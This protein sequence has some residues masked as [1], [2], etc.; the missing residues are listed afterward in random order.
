MK[1]SL[2]NNYMALM[3]L[4][5]FFLCSIYI[6]D[7]LKVDHDVARRGANMNYTFNLKYDAEIEYLAQEARKYGT[8]LTITDDSG[9]PTPR[10]MGAIEVGY[11]VLIQSLA[12]AGVKSVNNVTLAQ[13]HVFSFLFFSLIFCA[14]LGIVTRKIFPVSFVVLALLLLF[15]YHN[16]PLIYHIVGIWTLCTSFPFITFCAVLIMLKYWK[17]DFSM[18]TVLLLTAL[19]LTGGV[20]RFF[21]ES[22]SYAYFFTIVSFLAIL[23]S[24]YNRRNP[25]R[26]VINYVGSLVLVILSF[27]AVLPLIN[28]SLLYH[29]SSKTGLEARPYASFSH[30]AGHVLVVSLGR[31]ENPFGYYYSDYFA[32]ETGNKL[33]LRKGYG[34]GNEWSSEYHKVLLDYYVSQIMRHPFHYLKFLMKSFY[35]YLKFIPYSL[36]LDTPTRSPIGAHLPV[37]K[38]DVEYDTYDFV[39]Y[40]PVQPDGTVK[41]DP[42]ALINLRSAYFYLTTIEWMVFFAS[43]LLF[44]SGFV[45]YK[46]SSEDISLFIL[47]MYSAFIFYSILRILI[48]M[49]GWTSIVTYYTICSI[50]FAL[51]FDHWMNRLHKISQQAKL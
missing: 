12:L 11:Y 16:E 40:D 14:L 10:E 32:L 17:S 19:G 48:P 51:I 13:L 18:K 30:G 45:I 50:N 6:F 43:V 36:F 24:R 46:K 4:F 41:R 35:D 37:V 47:G 31:Y 5:V 22:E 34:P 1:I 44:L 38:K 27:S 7:L 2:K 33:L 28:T 42:T 39:G 15:R 20:M 29:R 26:L 21:R 9:K 3:F 25:R 23:A 8:V 49:H